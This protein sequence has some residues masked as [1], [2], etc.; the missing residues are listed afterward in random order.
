MHYE[1]VAGPAVWYGRDLAAHPQDWIRP[2][3]A[4]EVAEVSAAVGAFIETK[5]PLTEISPERFPL[6]RLGSVMRGVLAELL[7]GRGFIL[8][9]GLPVESW[10]REQQ[11]IAYM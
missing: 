10:T 2:F 7:E 6:P 9:R 5:A 4:D 3:T 11:A 1:P 8:M